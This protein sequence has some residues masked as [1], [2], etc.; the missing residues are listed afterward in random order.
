MRRGTSPPNFS[1][2]DKREQKPTP[3]RIRDRGNHYRL[4]QAFLG[5]VET[6]IALNR[7]A[8]GG[9]ALFGI[10]TLWSLGLTIHGITN[11]RDDRARFEAEW[12]HGEI[13]TA[14]ALD[15]VLIRPGLFRS[16]IGP[17]PGLSFS[18]RF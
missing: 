1:T 17:T 13:E 4:P 9:A 3:Q 15:R 7:D 10:L 14:A 18:F 11:L 5:A 12:P 2:R 6:I 8:T 16:Q